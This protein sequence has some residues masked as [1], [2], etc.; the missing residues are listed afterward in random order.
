MKTNK[1]LISMAVYLGTFCGMFII[2]ARSI[3]LP[4]ALLQLGAEKYYDLCVLSTSLAMCMV[5]P[6]SGKL[7]DIYG[8]K[9]IFVVGAIS[10]VISNILS[11]VAIN[12][13]MYMCGLVGT[14]IAYGLINSVQLAILNDISEPNERAQKVG[15]V[16]IANT[17]ASF[18]GPILGGFFAD[19]ISWRAVYIAVIPV[20]LFCTFA[21][22][23]YKEIITTAKRLRFDF[24]GLIALMI[25]MIP[26]ILLLSGRKI[27]VYKNIY[28]VIVLSISV[29]LGIVAVVFI[30]RNVQAPIIPYKLFRSKN[31]AFSITAYMICSI[32]FAMINYLPLYYQQVRMLSATISGLIIIPRQIGQLLSGM[33]L[34]KKM[35]LMTKKTVPV[36]AGFV[37]FILAAIAMLTYAENT[38]VILIALAEL[39]FGLGYCTLMVATQSNSQ[40]DLPKES[41]GSGTA[42]IGFVG[43]FGNTIGAAIG[44]VFLGMVVSVLFGLKMFFLFNLALF[45]VGV[46]TGMIHGKREGSICD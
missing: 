16:S 17:V 1:K 30:E 20:L 31:Y 28:L 19:Y 36:V 27:G 3:I 15:N 46:I 33:Y 44:A 12:I 7:S 13:F 21:I 4:T 26:S 14:G 10:F 35:S 25:A 38:S 37:F 11:T 6:I 45:I 2:T 23:G 29:I 5:L 34:R 18:I 24:G 9:I 42:L 22:L 8:R 40:N 39:L 43:A 32:G 41:V